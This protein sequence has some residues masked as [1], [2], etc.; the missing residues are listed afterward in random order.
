[1]YGQVGFEQESGGLQDFA[2]ML[3]ECASVAADVLI[4]QAVGDRKREFVRA[5]G[6]LRRFRRI[7]RGR[8]DRDAELF[9]VG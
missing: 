2:L 7:D 3:D 4:I 1:M 8:D 5:H 6:L 9:Q